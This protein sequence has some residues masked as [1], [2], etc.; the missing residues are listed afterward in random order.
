[1]DMAKKQ[2]RNL[3]TNSKKNHLQ[4]TTKIQM[5]IIRELLENTE[6]IFRGSISA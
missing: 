2:I 3:E 4:H 5:K 1:M 6:N